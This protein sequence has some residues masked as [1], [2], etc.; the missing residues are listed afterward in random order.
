MAI[1]AGMI[2]LTASNVNWTNYL[3]DVAE[4]A[5]HSVTQGID[6]YNY[7]LSDLARV[8]ASF[9]EFREGSKQNPI[10]VIRN[11]NDFLNHLHFGFLIWGKMSSAITIMERTDLEIILKRIKGGCIIVASG[12]LNVWKNAIITILSDSD[13]QDELQWIFSQCFDCFCSLGLEDIWYD[14]TKHG[15]RNETYLLEPK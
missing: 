10:E 3:K 5:S 13:I 14:F 11:A 1:Q 6:A 15:I 12:T 2:P 9:G 7:K 4:L 8:I